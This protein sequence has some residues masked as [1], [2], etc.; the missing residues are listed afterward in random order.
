[1]PL[2]LNSNVAFPLLVPELSK[3]KTLLPT[4]QL[5]AWVNY[6]GEKS[7]LSSAHETIIMPCMLLQKQWHYQ[8]HHACKITLLGMV[9]D[10]GCTAFAQKNPSLGACPAP[11]FPVRNQVLGS[12][13][14]SRTMARTN[15]EQSLWSG[16]RHPVTLGGR[17]FLGTLKQVAVDNIM[18]NFCLETSAQKGTVVLGSSKKTLVTSPESVRRLLKTSTRT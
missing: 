16:T 3:T 11:E 12:S 17:G 14:P 9:P 6:E 5:V 1:M 18:A 2:T 4:N 8:K 7:T 13:V 15:P 10:W